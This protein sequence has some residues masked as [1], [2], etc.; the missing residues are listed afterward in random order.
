MRYH[1]IIPN[2]DFVEKIGEGPQS[3][4]YKAFHKKKPNRLLALKVLK[5]VSL[6]ENQK[7]YFRQKIEHLKVLHDCR[8]ILPLSFE[9]KGGARFIT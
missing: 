4:V 7:A 2:Y 9:E 8:L 3:V 5:A 1:T 6:P